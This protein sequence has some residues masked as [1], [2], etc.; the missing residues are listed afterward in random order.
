MTVSQVRKRAYRSARQAGL[1]TDTSDAVAV[2]VAET[3]T[4]TRLESERV[5]DAMISCEIQKHAA[6]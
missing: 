6:P 4:R 3:V 1:D 5:I 2:R